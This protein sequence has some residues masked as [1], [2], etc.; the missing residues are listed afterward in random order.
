MTVLQKRGGEVYRFLRQTFTLEGR[1]E[2]RRELELKTYQ[3][4]LT[5]FNE[6]LAPF[7][8]KMR[9][10][11]DGRSMIILPVQREAHTK[12]H[13][14]FPSGQ[15]SYLDL[16]VVRRESAFVFTATTD[17][18]DWIRMLAKKKNPNDGPTY[19]QRHARRI[20]RDVF[21]MDEN[22][23]IVEA[24]SGHGYTSVS[25]ELERN[26]RIKFPR[27]FRNIK[28]IVDLV[29]MKPIPTIPEQTVA[30]GRVTQ[31]LQRASGLNNKKSEV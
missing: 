8:D 3:T 28:H 12:T 6:A 31:L 22:G 23:S 25:R 13:P 1:E 14:T 18:D 26:M 2:K 29:E 5:R 4:A 11:N 10:L 17:V 7:E 9:S 21:I 19:R 24:Q 20:R 30:L 27:R 15:I 16:K